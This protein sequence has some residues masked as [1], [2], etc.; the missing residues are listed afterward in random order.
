[1]SVYIYCRV[2]S[3][4][5]SFV[6]KNATFVASAEKPPRF[7]K[8]YFLFFY[9]GYTATFILEGEIPYFSLKHLAK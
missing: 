1:M 7:T 8:M 6:P 2:A 3:P 9:S 4:S 5:T